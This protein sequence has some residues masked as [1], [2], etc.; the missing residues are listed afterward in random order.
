MVDVLKITSTIPVNNKVQNLSNKL[1]SDAVFDIENPNQVTKQ[2]PK[3]K[4]IDEESGRQSLLKNLNKEIFEPLLRSTRAQADSVRKL[5]LMARLFEMSSGILSERFLEKVF[6]TPQEMLT[7]LMTWEKGSAIFKGE[8]FDSLRMLAKLEGQPKLKAAIVSILKHFDCYVHQENSLNAIVKQ[9]RDLANK[10]IKTEA[11]EIRQQIGILDTMIGL[12]KISRQ[13]V[14]AGQIPASEPD[15]TMDMDSIIKQDKTSQAE[16]K[17]YLK[18]ELIPVLGMVAKRHQGSD[19]IHN[20]VLAIVHNIVRYDKADPGLLEEAVFQLGDNLKPMTNLTDEDIIEM[21]KLVF[22]N[23][24]E[25]QKLAEKQ[26]AEKRPVEKYGFEPENNNLATLLLRA[27]DKSGPSKINS[28]AQNLLM[29]LVQS[30]SPVLPLLHFTIPFR[31]MDENTYGE[32]F[33]DKDCGERRGG[34]KEAKNIFFTIQS[35]KYG[36]FE[37]DL[38]ARD[39]M[40]DLDIRCPDALVVPL[41]ET[42]VKWKEIIEE[43]GFRLASYHVG[44]Y[45]ESQTIL[46]RFPKLVD[47]KAGL[48]V[49][50]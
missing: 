3:T 14:M 17:A 1:P 12:N 46:M 42:R 43:Q 8:F 26:N 28:L 21:R 22:E 6:V 48:N 36:N 33:V 29:N 11:A 37:V 50:V 15:A 35:D 30:E 24:I 49:K 27:M 47:G 38:L 9:G 23:A 7:E 19:R 20:Q 44:V 10:L 31:F 32:F 16:I 45:Q 13:S 5:V 18:N 34:A 39:N 40:I 25:E 41:K 2:S 4:N